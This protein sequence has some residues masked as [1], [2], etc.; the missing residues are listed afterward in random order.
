MKKVYCFIIAFILCG[1]LP[2]PGQSSEFQSSKFSMGVVG[3][4]NFANMYFPNSQDPDDQETTM[5]TGFGAGLVFDLRLSEKL[6]AH[7]QP[8][9]LQKGCNIK[10]GNDPVNQP[11]GEINSAAIEIPVLIK[12]TF[13]NKIRPYIVAGPSLGFNLKSEIAFELTGFKFKGDMKEVT[14]PFDLGITLGG[15]V[16]V[17]LGFGIIFLESR[18]THGLINQRKTGS[19][20]LDSDGVTFELP[21]DKDEDK[22]T[23][24]GVQLM[25]GITFPF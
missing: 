17:P 11:E 25:L 14:G 15:G 5:H 24:R 6:F 23:N 18:Y 10:E 16:Q 22:Y 21:T 1:S 8:M 12:Y 19:V 9:Y 2:V 3:G 4:L 7:I 13:G 20:L